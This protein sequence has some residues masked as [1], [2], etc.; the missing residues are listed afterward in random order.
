MIV[1]LNLF[2]LCYNDSIKLQFIIEI[3]NAYNIV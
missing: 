1:P 2:D 3:E